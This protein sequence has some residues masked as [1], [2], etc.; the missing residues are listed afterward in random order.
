MDLIS[1]KQ[2]IWK[3][4]LIVLGIVA[5][6]ATAAYA[7]TLTTLASFDGTNGNE[8]DAAVV[9]GVDGNFYGTTV[10]GGALGY[11]SVFKM[12]PAGTVTT[13]YSFT[14]AD[15]GR[16]PYAPLLLGFDG[17]FYGTT[18]GAG[19][20]GL[21]GTVFKI[22]PGGTLT[23][24]H[25]F[26]RTDGSVPVAG[27]VQ[28]DNG[29]L[30]GTTLE[31]GANEDGT[32][33]KISTSGNLTTLHNFDETDGASPNGALYQGTDGNFYGT[34]YAGGTNSIGTVFKIS[35][36]GSFT[37]LHSFTGYPTDGSEPYS[38]LVQASNGTFY[39]N[40]WEGGASDYGSIFKMSSAGVV[41]LEHSFDGTDGGN[42]AS[43]LIQA[44][45]G[46][47]Y[48]TADGAGASSSG[49][50][51]G[52]GT[53]FEITPGGV[54]TLLETFDSTNGAYPLA[55]LLQGTNGTLYGTT[56][57]GGTDN[58]GI[59]LSL[60]VRLGPFVALLPNSGKVGATVTIL[61]NNLTGATAVSFNGTDAT[62]TVVSKTEITATV[63]TGAT[64]GKIQVTTPHATLK[65]NVSFRVIG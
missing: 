11:G 36:T 32:I 40:T 58:D 57:K 62:F 64:S 51:E 10:F 27:L 8:P 2:N 14:D 37:S 28:A 49:C 15:D 43:P 30:Y 45:N 19:A 16:Y 26:E 29:T 54:F 25:S 39:G 47:L 7:Q 59:V 4:S 63:P 61:G 1:F 17:N 34:T 22:T 52:C 56:S 44:T 12:T 24:L 35:P 31:G 9:Q 18:S 23:T 21:W 13:L 41:T 50:V 46:N 65:S 20:S 55:S 42:P 38:A 53:I 6:S 60:N 3:I 5:A 33:F 48:G